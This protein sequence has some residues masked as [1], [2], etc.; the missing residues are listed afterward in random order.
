MI[1]KIGSDVIL[2]LFIF[3]WNFLHRR[4]TIARWQHF[5][6]DETKT[7]PEARADAQTLVLERV[8]RCRDEP[9]DEAFWLSFTDFVCVI[10]PFFIYMVFFK[11]FNSVKHWVSCTP[12]SRAKGIASRRDRFVHK[13]TTVRKMEIMHQVPLLLLL[14]CISLSLGVRER[15]RSLFCSI[16]QGGSPYILSR[17]EAIETHDGCIYQ[18]LKSK[19]QEM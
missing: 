14:L 2:E 6:K 3:Y 13:S 9:V 15:P 10:Q 4:K 8:S 1:Y 18:Q 16:F 5:D 7:R 12:R 19:K 17:L 11:C